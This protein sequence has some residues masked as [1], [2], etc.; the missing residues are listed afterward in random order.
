MTGQTALARKMESAIAARIGGE[1]V[2]KK[3]YGDSQPDIISA[4]ITGECK[5]R[6]TLALETWMQQVEG[7]NEG[8]GRIAAVFSRLKGKREDSTLVTVRLP[9]FLSL[10][11]ALRGSNDDI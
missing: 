9:V 2:E 8:T 3:H 7:Y 6:A 1:R 4:E 5:L 11:T 10:L